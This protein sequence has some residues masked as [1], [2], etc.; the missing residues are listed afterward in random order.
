MMMP[1]IPAST[2]A[3]GTASPNGTP[4]SVS[5]STKKG[6]IISSSPWAKLISRRMPKMMAR[7]MAIRA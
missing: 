1:T 3:I 2:T 7:P 6:P 4:T 5:T